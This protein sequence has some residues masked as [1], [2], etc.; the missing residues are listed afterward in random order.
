MRRALA[1][2]A[3]LAA[4]CGPAAAQDAPPVVR[5]ITVVGNRELPDADLIRAGRL[6][7]R[8]PLPED[9]DRI[10]QRLERHYRTVGYSFARVTVTFAETTGAVTIS[11]SEGI[12]DKIEFQ[13][14]DDKIA[15]SFANDF[16]VRAGDVFN[17]P[18]A[19]S[20]LDALLQR[21]RGAVRRTKETFDLVDR[22]GERV[23][24]V[25]LKEPAGRFRLVPDLGDRE[26]WFTSVDGFVPSLGFGAAVFNHESFNHAFVAGH[27]SVK[28]ASGNV[29]YALGFER[30][31]FASTRLFVG[32][33]LR[34]LTASDDQWQITSTEASL[35]A[36]GPRL[37]YRDYYRERGVQVY[38]AL[39]VHPRAELIA[40]YRD[41]R[42]EPL[43]VESDFSFWNS[44]DRFRPNR[45]AVDGRLRALVFGATVDGLGFDRESLEATYQRHQL[46]SLFGQRLPSPE[47]DADST[48][49]WHL[50]W[51]SEIS[52]PDALQSDFDFTRHIV[53]ARADVPLSLHQD[54]SVRAVGGWSTG[55]LPPQRQFSA[56]GIGSVH[57]Y[58]F[59]EQIGDS[60][61][62]VNLEYSLGD[63]TG[64]RAIGFFD[65]GRAARRDVTGTPWLNGVGFGIGM[66]VVRLDFGYK[67]DDIPSSFQFLLRFVR[68]F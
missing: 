11:V 6:H 22:S 2:V 16:A 67:L 18:R 13:G 63:R 1:V 50:D 28:T 3:L 33:E 19:T 25:D 29:G 32:G 49:L 7:L 61:A 9:S 15:V 27:I 14:V 36:I 52:T 10:A 60:L 17:R 48:V 56:G 44:D 31:F 55:T 38:A 46:T 66:G 24:I 39:R 43:A 4:T 20:A 40:A 53:A 41:E 30:P 35:A 51:T 64:L 47:H 59:K 21:T 34:D 54:F 45:L 37:S 68:T 26:D 58:E 5:T 12:I 57:G 62:L 65:V 8:E 42:Q 23:L